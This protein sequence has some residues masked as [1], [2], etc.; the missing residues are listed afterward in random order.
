MSVLEKHKFGGGG[1]GLGEENVF[2]S[3]DNLNSFCWSQKSSRTVSDL[4][5]TI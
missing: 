2:L 4:H 1:G 5:G 3:L